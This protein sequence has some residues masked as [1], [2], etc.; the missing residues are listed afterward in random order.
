M[1]FMNPSTFRLTLTK[2]L[3]VTAM[4][5]SSNSFAANY[6][7]ELVSP[8]AVGTAP[9]SG[10]PN[11]TAGNRIFKAYPG[12]EYNIRAVVI[13]G[14]Y[15]YTFSLSNAPSG[16]TIN[17]RTG[18]VVWPN[19]SGTAA[20]PTI[21]V[22]DGEGTSRSS[23]W[24]IAV[25]TAGFK[26]VDAA[27]GSAS[28]TGA[29]GSPFRALSDLYTN[30]NSNNTDIVYFRNGTYTMQNLPRA[31]VG[32][33]W[34]RVEV[35]GRMSNM[36]IAYPG[37]SPMIDFGFVPNVNAGAILRFAGDNAYIDG[38]QTR[39]SRVIGFQVLIG[40]YGVFRR[41]H[42]RDLNTIRANLDGSN[43]AH[44]MCVTGGAGNYGDYLTVQDNEFSNALSDMALKTY[45]QR[46]MLIEDNNLHDLW[47]GTEL[48][49]DMPQFTYRGNRHANIPGR[50]I[51]GNMHETAT[52]G[53]IL[54]NLVLGVNSEAALDINQDGMARRIDIYRNTFVGR[55]R[56]RNT[57]LLDGP[58]RFQN[59]VIVS[60]DAGTSLLSRIHLESVLDLL[61]ITQLNDLTGAPSAGI[62]DATGNLTSNYGQY[63]GS[64][65][66]QQGVVPRPPTGVTAQ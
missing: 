54:F 15:P 38:F 4:V 17:A 39:N 46:K 14:A 41:L 22:T 32:T 49:A 36:W 43:S 30:T 34:E 23:P 42:M 33:A 9:I 18:L 63:V 10:G 59:N 11:I 5:V 57:D 51:G 13:G 58:F 12:I 25:T 31:S 40:D 44:I 56:V 2:L 8:R 45:T 28:G 48:K 6:T 62:V 20:S 37:E 7:L 19:P 64:R 50:S 60:N 24:T 53:E 61:R 27:N 65:G 35:E 55:V 26:F 1:K 47:F 29:I 3:V 66:H 21:T 16:M 52:S